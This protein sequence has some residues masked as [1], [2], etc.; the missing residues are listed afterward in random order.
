MLA[1]LGL[2][3]ALNILLGLKGLAPAEISA[4]C[5]KGNFNVAHGLAWSYYIGYLRL[6]LPAWSTVVTR[7]QLTA[8]SASQSSRPGFELTISITTTCYGVQ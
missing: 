3:Q 5:E 7:S 1:L 2:S 4:V 8:T 6:I